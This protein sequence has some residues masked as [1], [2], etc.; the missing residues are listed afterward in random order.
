MVIHVCSA[1]EIDSCVVT[2]LQFVDGSTVLVLAG[3]I[4]NIVCGINESNRHLPV[5]NLIGPECI[6]FIS[7][8]AC[9][10]CS[11]VEKTP[12]GNAVLVCESVVKRED[13]PF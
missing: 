12:V 5:P 1:M 2:P 4:V 8:I 6:R 9:E 13:L 3:S 7:G 11:Q 10:S